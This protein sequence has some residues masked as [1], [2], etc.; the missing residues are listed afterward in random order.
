MIALLLLVHSGGSWGIKVDH[1]VLRRASFVSNVMGRG[2]GRS[3]EGK[4]VVVVLIGPATQ[5]PVA[6]TVLQNVIHTARRHRKTTPIHDP[7]HKG[8]RTLS[9]RIVGLDLGV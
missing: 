7:V 8:I 2:N 5:I 1:R 4:V 3:I 6:P 9:G